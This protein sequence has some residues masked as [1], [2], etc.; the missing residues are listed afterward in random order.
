[1]ASL[2]RWPDSGQRAPRLSPALHPKS[3][4][5]FVSNSSP[6]GAVWAGNDADGRRRPTPAYVDPSDLLANNFVW[7]A[8]ASPSL[9]PFGALCRAGKGIAGRWQCDWK[10]VAEAEKGGSVRQN[11]QETA[12]GPVCGGGVR[13]G[14]AL[15]WG[16]SQC[17]SMDTATCLAE[18]LCHGH[19]ALGQSVTQPSRGVKYAVN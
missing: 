17:H 1:M 15:S 11:R 5:S 8:R 7:S 19:T 18:G 9:T 4:T 14:R 12:V 3:N 10:P 16:C 13:V 2:G 6:W